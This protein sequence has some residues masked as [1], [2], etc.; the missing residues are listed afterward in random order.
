MKKQTNMTLTAHRAFKTCL[1]LLIGMRQDV[2]P[3]GQL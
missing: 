3:S 2:F 1:L